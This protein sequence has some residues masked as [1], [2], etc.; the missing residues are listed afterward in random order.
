MTTKVSLWVYPLLF[1]AHH[2]HVLPSKKKKKRF[3]LKCKSS[4]STSVA[5]TNNILN[6]LPWL[7]SFRTFWLRNATHGHAGVS[8]RTPG[9]TIFRMMMWLSSPGVVPCTICQPHT[10]IPPCWPLQPHLYHFPA[11]LLTLDLYG[12]SSRPPNTPNSL[13][14]LPMPL[15]LFRCTHPQLSFT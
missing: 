4:H 15:C 12:P 13:P 10:A 6:F 5:L 1:Q 9:H 14:I 8:W 2:I 7:V 3:S 11:L